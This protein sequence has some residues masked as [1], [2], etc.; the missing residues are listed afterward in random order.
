VDDRAPTDLELREA[1]GPQISAADLYAVLCLRSEVFVVEQQCAYL[2]PDGRDL[3]PGTTHLWFEA[4]GAAVASYLRIIDEPGGGHRIGR[5]VTAP[6]HRGRQLA[7]RLLQHALA[8][9]DGPVVL[10][11]QSH[12]VAMYERHGF[13][14]DGP[15]YLD[16]GILH[17]PMR[18]T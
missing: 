2:D 17:T 3:D 5:V 1:S 15:E 14:V 10:H 6:E 9:L 13:A 8:L 4:P 18:L 16:D 12:L 7:G 11:A